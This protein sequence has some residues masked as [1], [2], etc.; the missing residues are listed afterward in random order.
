MKG[1]LLCFRAGEMA[2]EAKAPATKPNDPS[3]TPGS[4]RVEGKS[5]AE[6]WP[7]TSIHDMV[8]THMHAGVHKIKVMRYFKTINIFT[9]V[10]NE[11]IYYIY[12]IKIQL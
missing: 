7:L 3:L 5:T 11:A 1:L 2:Q 8:F 12:T 6:S 10:C 9:S 4:S